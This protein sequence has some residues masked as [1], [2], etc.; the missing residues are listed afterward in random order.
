MAPSCGNA[1]GAIVERNERELA[2]KENGYGEKR[3]C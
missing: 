3:H 2:L 1:G